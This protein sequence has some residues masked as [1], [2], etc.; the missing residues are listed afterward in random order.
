MISYL[1]GI[2]QSVGDQKID[3]RAG[4][5]G[6][7]LQVPSSTIFIVGQ[8]VELYVY[9]HWN[10]ENGFSLFG[11][12]ENMDKTVFM[13]LISCTGIGPKVG[14][15]VLQD[16]GSQS[17]IAAM[18][19]G[20]EK[21]LSKVNGIGPK[22]AAFIALQLKS[23]VADLI[24]SG[25]LALEDTTFKEWQTVMQALESLNYSRQEIANALQFVKSQN[26][27]VPTFDIMMRQALSFLAKQSL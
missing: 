1:A 12:T 26:T 2:V 15:A 13:L 10:Q 18:Y 8:A 21:I 16:L 22:K 3:V 7:E 17:F 27:N 19:E 6:F 14:L 25:A 24:K 5:F 23:K 9:L 11:F 20:D 4:A